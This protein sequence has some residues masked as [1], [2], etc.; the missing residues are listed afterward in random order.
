MLHIP[1]EYCEAEILA[2]SDWLAKPAMEP[3]I[4]PSVLFIIRLPAYALSFLMRSVTDLMEVLARL[5]AALLES[6]TS[7][8]KLIGWDTSRSCFQGPAAFVKRAGELLPVECLVE[9]LVSIRSIASEV[10]MQTAGS[11]SGLVQAPKRVC[12]LNARLEDNRD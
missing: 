9:G 11:V 7:T 5:Y 12:S 2:P 6:S 1:R 4:G 10:L 8:E 3:E